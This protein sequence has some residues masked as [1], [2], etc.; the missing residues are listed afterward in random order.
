MK[1][2]EVRKR[3]V[4]D[5]HGAQAYWLPRKPMRTFREAWDRIE[6]GDVNA[7]ARL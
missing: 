7:G 2:D 6:R 4:R 5:Q 3:A 1:P